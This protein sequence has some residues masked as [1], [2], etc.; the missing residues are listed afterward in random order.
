MTCRSC[1]Q[2][3]EKFVPRLLREED[4][5]CAVCGSRD[6]KQGVGG[7]VLGTGTRSVSRAFAAEACSTSGFSWA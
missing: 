4:R 7:G 1:G 2:T 3:C 6:V 5:V